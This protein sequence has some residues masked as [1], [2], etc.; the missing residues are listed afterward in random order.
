LILLCLTV[1][2]TLGGQLSDRRP[3]TQTL[4]TVTASGGFL[5]GLIPLGARPVPPNNIFR[6]EVWPTY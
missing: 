4:C 6:I 2:Y 1:G 5:I 3:Y